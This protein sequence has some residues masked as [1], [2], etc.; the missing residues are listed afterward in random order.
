MDTLPCSVVPYGAT[1]RLKHSLGVLRLMLD[2]I[3]NNRMAL[4]AFQKQLLI[5]SALLHDAGSPPL[6]HLTEPFLW[7]INGKDG[8]SFLEDV[9]A[10]STAAEV[11][12]SFNIPYQK[13]VE[14]VTGN[15]GPFSD[16]LHGSIDVDNLDNVLRYECVSSGER[17]FDAR[18]IA[19]S[20]CFRGGRWEFPMD[21]LEEVRK[22]QNARRAVYAT[23]YGSTHLALASMAYRAVDLVFQRGDLPKDFFRFTDD[24]AFDALR[25]N[26]ESRHLIDAVRA[27]RRYE[28][29]ASIETTTPKTDL[30]HLADSVWNARS[31]V[32]EYIAN[33]T[34]V[35]SWA[36]CAYVSKGRDVRKI[37][38]PFVDAHGKEYRDDVKAEPIY[39][40]KVYAHPE[41]ADRVD[42]RQCA[43]RLAE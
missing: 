26:E 40:L 10:G 12:E 42:I 23:I 1:D 34:G 7:N 11:M 3:K 39:R 31:M 35:P 28:E 17:S 43:G 8:E 16:I 41:Y 37:D 13:V 36:I 20:Y 6:S 21:C 32:A 19:A 29:I 38:I 27:G 9:L 4:T 2:V 24:E 30:R 15:A 18:K 22:W 33:Q 25:L 5:V 14:M